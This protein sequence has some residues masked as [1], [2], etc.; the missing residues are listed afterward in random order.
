MTDVAAVNMLSMLRC[1]F[2]WVLLLTTI[3]MDLLPLRVYR[4][5]PA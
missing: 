4:G 1:A 5:P 2:R 3:G